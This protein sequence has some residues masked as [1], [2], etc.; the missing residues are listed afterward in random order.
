MLN[1]HNIKWINSPIHFWRSPI[2]QSIPIKV[3]KVN[4]SIKLKLKRILLLRF[5]KVILKLIFKIEI[6]LFFK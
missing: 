6:K 3:F 2:K 4:M 5:K 1:K